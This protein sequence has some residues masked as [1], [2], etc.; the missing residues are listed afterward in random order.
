MS[1]ISKQVYIVKQ[2]YLN[3]H[4][5][6]RKKAQKNIEFAERLDLLIEKTGLKNLH[7]VAEVKGI[8]YNT[9]RNYTQIH[10]GRV[11]M[12]DQLLIISEK[13][14]VSVDWLLTG[15]EPG[16]VKDMVQI[17]HI[18]VIS[19]FKDK[20]F[21]KEI[22]EALVV[23][24]KHDKDAFNKIGGEIKGDAKRLKGLKE[25]QI[26]DGEPIISVK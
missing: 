8:N 18:N 11:P 23:L 4:I 19:N 22:N 17:E 13:F 10:R 2:N 21:A 12:W 7:R 5:M 25:P 16:T 20:K 15:R 9:L 1:Y 14:D 3:K 6:T 26:N 24:E